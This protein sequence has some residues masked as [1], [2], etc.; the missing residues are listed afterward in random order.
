MRRLFDLIN[1]IGGASRS[2]VSV[3]PK[4]RATAWTSA[5]QL[6]SIRPAPISAGGKMTAAHPAPTAQPGPRARPQLHDLSRRPVEAGPSG[7]CA[8]GFANDI[9]GLF[10]WRPIRTSRGNLASIR[11]KGADPQPS[12]HVDGAPGIEIKAS[13]NE[14]TIARPM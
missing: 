5:G 4:A 14:I 10:R 11:S 6:A 7:R 12:L 13:G 8:R 1:L 3:T 2:W 9:E